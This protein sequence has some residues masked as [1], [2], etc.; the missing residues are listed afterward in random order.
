MSSIDRIDDPAEPVGLETR[1][2]FLD[3]ETYKSFGH[4]L[5]SEPLAELTSHLREG[6]LI[7]HITDIT[8]SEIERHIHEDAAK[9]AID[10]LGTSK[11]IARW[12]ARSPGT[13]LPELN[14]IDAVK[15]AETAFNEFTLTMTYVWKAQLHSALEIPA[16]SV[17]DLYFQRK[18]PFDGNSKEFP[19]AFVVLALARWCRGNE[20]KMY[21]VTADAAMQRAASDTGVLLPVNSLQN[22]LQMVTAAETPEVLEHVDDLVVSQRFLDQL[23]EKLQEGI[24]WLGTVYAGDLPE[25]E[26]G[27]IRVTGTPE[28][29]RVSVLSASA[30]RIGVLLAVKMPV[31]V[32]VTYADLSKASYDKEDDIWLGAE[33]AFTEIDAMPI[34]RMFVEIDPSDD[35]IR[36]IE[37][38]TTDVEVAEERNWEK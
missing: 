9:A 24:G 21:V 7:L 27:D 15:L 25:G 34:V 2:V 13:S 31:T 37:F 6:A 32:E 12:R 4:N 18:P 3:T 8:L 26:A 17:F 1:H 30:G 29:E 19:D 23:E 20:L 14:A 11:L 5:K 10:I 33:T 38:I 35:S 28:I 16:S 22:L 36:K